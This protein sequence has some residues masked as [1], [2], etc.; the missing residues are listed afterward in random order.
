MNYKIKEIKWER[1]TEYENVED[2][3]DEF[4]DGTIENNNEFE[5]SIEKYNKLYNAVICSPDYFVLDKESFLSLEGA[6]EYIKTYIENHVNSFLEN[7]L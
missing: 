6:K 4:Y 1:K 2:G 5:L 3:P 7:K